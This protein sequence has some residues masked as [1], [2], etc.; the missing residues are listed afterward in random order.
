MLHLKKIILL[1]L[2]SIFFLVST[3]VLIDHLF[4]NKTLSSSF[5]YEECKKV[6]AHRGYFKNYNENSLGSYKAALELG[7]KGVEL[8]VFYDTVLDNYV[9]SHDIPYNKKKGKLLMLE[10]VFD[11]IGDTFYWLDFK[12]LEELNGSDRK[13]SILKMIEIVD[14]F[15]VKEQIIIESKNVNNLFQFSKV[16]FHTSYWVSLK[17]NS[18]SFK[19]FKHLYTLKIKYILGYFSSISMSYKNYTEAKLKLLPE[20]PVLLFTVN[21]E[22]MIDEYLKVNQVKIILSDE[23]FYDKEVA[24]CAQQ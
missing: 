8:D 9:V 13:N 3:K 2:L 23:N 12:N 16:G 24:V 5:F 1:F 4:I 7:A 6:W 14:K 18:H 11:V 20:L 10:E 22:S 17:E 19:A 15:R 21:D